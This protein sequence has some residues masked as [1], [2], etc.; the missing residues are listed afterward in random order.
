MGKEA[1]RTW[2]RA[3]LDAAFEVANG[4]HAESCAVGELFL[5]EPERETVL[6]ECVRKG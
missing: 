2:T 1:Y 5:R 4:A 6:A 3:V